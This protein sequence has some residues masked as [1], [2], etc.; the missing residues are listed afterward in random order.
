MQIP[1]FGELSAF[2]MRPYR[3]EAAYSSRLPSASSPP[4]T[5]LLAILT[6]LLYGDKNLPEPLILA[7]VA[8][9]GWLPIRC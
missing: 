4:C 5:P 8:L 7:G 6:A 2:E 9:I 1:K 3:L